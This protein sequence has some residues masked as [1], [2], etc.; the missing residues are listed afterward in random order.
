MKRKCASFCFIWLTILSFP[1]FHLAVV[2]KE[3]HLSHW[4]QTK[5]ITLKNIQRINLNKFGKIE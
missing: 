3:G 2:E 5:V 4:V 1:F